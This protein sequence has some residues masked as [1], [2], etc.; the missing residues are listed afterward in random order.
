MGRMIPFCGIERLEASNL[1][2]LSISPI[3]FPVA[4]GSSV[5]PVSLGWISFVSGWSA[6]GG[7]VPFGTDGEDGTDDDEE[8]LDSSFLDGDR[9]LA[10]V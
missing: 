6:V 4:H 1:F 10:A 2:L 8:G 5:V 3:P 7:S 9:A